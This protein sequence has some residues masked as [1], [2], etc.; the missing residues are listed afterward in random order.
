M[1][2][3]SSTHG[4]AGSSL[5]VPALR[6]GPPQ[7]CSLCHAGTCM[8]SWA[9]DLPFRL[10]A[11]APFWCS[12][13]PWWIGDAQRVCT[14]GQQNLT[15]FQEPRT[16]C[17]Q[18]QHFSREQSSGLP[19]R[20]PPV[21]AGALLIPALAALAL[22]PS[23]SGELEVKFLLVADGCVFCPQACRRGGRSHHVQ[24]EPMRS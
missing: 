14:H 16:T 18:R 10:S 11:R 4:A 6:A 24:L 9:S 20:C 5:L 15:D 13:R 21:L 22:P 3:G 17:L 23:G 2:N 1:S 12:P 8:S 7:V 19:A